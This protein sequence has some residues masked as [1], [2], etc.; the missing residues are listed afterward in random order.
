[1]SRLV[2]FSRL[3]SSE[4][5]QRVAAGADVAT[6]P[7]D[8]VAIDES[9][10]EIRIATS[11]LSAIPYFYGISRDG[12]NFAHGTNVFVCARALGNGWRWNDRAVHCLARFQHTLGEDT[13]H[14]DIHRVPPASVITFREGRLDIR[15]SSF[16]ERNIEAANRFDAA[17]AISLV[18]EITAEIIEDKPVVIS[19]S[20][21]FDSRVLLSSVLAQGGKP[22]VATMGSDSATDVKIAGAIARKFSLEH[23]IVSLAPADYFKHARDIVRLTSGTKTADN[24]HTYLFARALTEFS[25]NAVHL[26]GSN[27]EYVRSYYFD[28]GILASGSRLAPRFLAELLLRTK[29]SRRRRIPLPVI[30]GVLADKDAEKQASRIMSDLLLPAGGWLNTLDHFYS[31]QRVRHFIGNGLALY[32][33]VLPTASPF[34]DYRFIALARAM[35]RRLKLNSRFLRRAISENVPELLDFPTDDSGISMRQSDRTFYW[36]RSRPSTGFNIFGQVADSE[37]GKSII[38]ESPHLDRFLDKRARELVI[39]KKLRPL[40]GLLMALHFASEE[41]KRCSEVT[42]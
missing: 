32:N 21:G 15:R 11:A 41:A 37:E 24:W 18:N 10:D 14:R 34:L 23:R 17:E 12:K 29:D 25:D 5:F 19:L 1:M 13:L 6:L 39:S 7:G 38:I 4:I 27:G 8:F 2:G 33:A 9:S 30:S 22:T 35:P 28:K 36:L 20:A 3:S 42:V 31:L 40:A 26:A 16:W